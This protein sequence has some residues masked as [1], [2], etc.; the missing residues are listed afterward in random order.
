MVASTSHGKAPSGAC[1]AAVRE[2]SS[3]SSRGLRGESAVTRGNVMDKAL[4]Q[5]Q[6]TGP[7]TPDVRDQQVPILYLNNPWP[8]LAAGPT[9]HGEVSPHLTEG[10]APAHDHRS[11]VRD[12]MQALRGPSQNGRQ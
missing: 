1:A 6:G 8:W 7:P 5:P 10:V 2:L 3:P 12:V 9:V 4:V 11:L